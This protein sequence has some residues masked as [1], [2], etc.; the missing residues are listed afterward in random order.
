MIARMSKAKIMMILVVILALS[1][2]SVTSVYAKRTVRF[3]YHSYLPLVEMMNEKLIPEYERMHPDIRVE[4]ETV[5]VA[6]FEPKLLTAVAA[7]MGPDIF[8]VPSWNGVS[9][10]RKGLLAPVDFQAMGYTSQEDLLDDFIPGCFDAYAVKGVLYGLSFD[11]G[12]LGLFYGVKDFVEVGLDPNSPPSTWSE[13]VTYGKKLV[14]YDKQGNIIRSAFQWPWGS[15][16]WYMHTFSPILNQTGARILDDEETKCLLNSPEGLKALRIYGD[17]VNDRISDPGAVVISWLSDVPEGYQSMVLSGP[18]SV[19]GYQVQYPDFKPIE[20]YRIGHFPQVEGGKKSGI[21]WSI[22]VGINSRSENPEDAWE[23]LRW[24]MREKYVD[25][26]L[27]AGNTPFNADLL[28]N[29]RVA[30]RMWYMSTFVDIMG[31]SEYAVKTDYYEQIKTSIGDMI[32]RVCMG[33]VDPQEAL[34]LA[35]IEINKLLK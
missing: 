16:V 24:I 3:W 1:V 2:C 26:F 18:F 33:G 9:Y 13:L 12:T 14:K 7:G 20:D 11:A 23:F 30:D 5:S 4:F 17:M 22:G 21:L 34:D 15:Y 31:Y 8:R 27:G 10:A 28:K 25:I 19:G 29:P 35:E 32:E 6:D